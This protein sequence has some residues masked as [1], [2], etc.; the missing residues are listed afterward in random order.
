[1]RTFA[2][3]EGQQWPPP[4]LLVLL[5]SL[6]VLGLFLVLLPLAPLL[7][8]LGLWQLEGLSLHLPH[9]VDFVHLGLQESGVAVLFHQLK[10]LIDK[11]GKKVLES[12]IV[13]YILTRLKYINT[14]SAF[15]TDYETAICTALPQFYH[16]TKNPWQI[17]ISEKVSSLKQVTGTRLAWLL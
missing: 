14:S 9:E 6:F 15:N 3:G 13:T 7:L 2:P 8:A 11:G 4:F 17:L 16:T 1:M 10:N 5:L 12:I